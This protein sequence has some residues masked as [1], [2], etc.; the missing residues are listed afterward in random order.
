[1]G[2]DGTGLDPAIEVQQS[3]ADAYRAQQRNKENKA[4]NVVLS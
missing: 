1:M 2:L 3:D 4:G